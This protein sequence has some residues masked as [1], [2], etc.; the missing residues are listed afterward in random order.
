MVLRYNIIMRLSLKNRSNTTVVIMAGGEGK[1]LWPLSTV[2]RPK[3]LSPEISKR[4]L[5]RETYDHACRIFSSSQIVVVT[6]E[7]LKEPTQKL[8]NIPEKNLVIQPKNMDTATAMAFTA[9]LLDA[10]FPDSTA[11]FLQSDHVISSWRK[12]GNTLKTVAKLAKICREP[13][14]IGTIPL[15][16]D[17]QFG[18]IKIGKPYK[19]KA[20]HVAE[21]FFEKPDKDTAQEF[22]NSGDYAWN[23]GIKGWH[24]SGLIDAIK[25]IDAKLYDQMVKLRSEIGSESYEKTLKRWYDQVEPRSFEKAISEHLDKLLVY[26]A[27]YEWRDIGSWRALYDLTPKDRANNAIV[28]NQPNQS[29][30]MINTKDSL[31]VTEQ[32]QVIVAGMDNVAV[33]QSGDTLLVCPREKLDTIR[34]SLE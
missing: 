24:I 26:V 31:I 32:K 4:T 16:A 10:R 30:H 21:G 17:T 18:Y 12:F 28:K 20:L 25:N 34:K 14:A 19:E 22:L 7:I 9:L 3:Q 15:W 11:L 33:V 5:L 1:R 6:T 27:D 13:I 2:E 29:F 8:L 23:T